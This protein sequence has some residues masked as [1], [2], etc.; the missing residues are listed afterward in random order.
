[1]TPTR[2]LQDIVNIETLKS[3]IE[4]S[5]W[6]FFPGILLLLFLGAGV[7]HLYSQRRRQRVYPQ[8]QRSARTRLSLPL[9]INTPVTQE[10]SVRTFDISLTGAFLPFDDLKNSMAF[11]SLVGKRSGIKVGDLVDIKVYTGRFSQISCQAR[12]IRYNFSDHS[13]P[14]KGIGIEFVN[15]SKKHQKI[16]RHLIESQHYRDVA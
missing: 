9:V 8:K 10:F 3:Q 1:M 4:M 16:L 6:E 14:P 13:L 15:L 2:H 7:Y 5:T 11:T 12:V